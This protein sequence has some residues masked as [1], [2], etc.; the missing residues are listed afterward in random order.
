MRASGFTPGAGFPLP[1]Q[2]CDKANAVPDVLELEGQCRGNGH[3]FA[4]AGNL[5]VIARER[6]GV[7]LNNVLESMRPEPLKRLRAALFAAG[8]IRRKSSPILK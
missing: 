7:A 2:P 6:L 4:R 1:F 5:P 8:P 3:L